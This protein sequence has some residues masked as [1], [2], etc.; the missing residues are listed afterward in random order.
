L[1]HSFA[2]IIGKINYQYCSII[3]NLF[4]EKFVSLVKIKSIDLFLEMHSDI[5]AVE[6]PKKH[7]GFLE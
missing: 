6:V 4:Q 3:K 5:S 2:K 7:F 1:T